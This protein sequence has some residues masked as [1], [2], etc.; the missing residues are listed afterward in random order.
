LIFIIDSN[1]AVSSEQG[2]GGYLEENSRRIFAA[3][4]ISAI[5]Y[6]VLAIPL[7]LIM[8]PYTPSSVATG[9]INTIKSKNY[10]KALCYYTDVPEGDMTGSSFV[11]SHLERTY[12]DISD[13]AI[14]SIQKSS[15]VNSY[16]VKLEIKKGNEVTEENILLKC[17]GSS[18]F[19]VIKELKVVFPFKVMDFVIK[20]IDGSKVYV[21]GVDAGQIKDG[22]LLI[23]NIIQGKHAFI[24]NIPEMA[25]SDNVEVEVCEST[26]EICLNVRAVDDFKKDI[27]KLISDFCK[28]WCEYCLT[29][30]N[31][32][33]KPYLTDKLFNEYINDT[34]RFNGSKY[35]ICENTMEFKDMSLADEDNLFYTVN[36]TWHLKEAITIKGLVFEDNNKSTL[37]QNQY[38]QW[39]YHIIRSG[40]LWKLDIGE[41]LS[42]V[43]KEIK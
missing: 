18:F 31:E 13:I 34:E 29:Q 3:A 39:K 17:V 25:V 4:L 26:L 15:V 32:A 37:E 10:D 21:D 6:L 36:E 5:C 2:L 28:G 12:H 40:G 35:L 11:K 8:G 27:E 22:M 23:K 20:G 1:Y 16:D 41:R 30:E 43:K 24:A 7:F 38:A 33:I 42:F 19:G 14:K 9:Y